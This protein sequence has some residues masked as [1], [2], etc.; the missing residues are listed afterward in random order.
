MK[1]TVTIV[2]HSG[3]FHSD[4]I[5]GVATVSLKL[6]KEGIP[7]KIVR[8]RDPS[9]REKADYV[10]DTGSVYDPDIN[11]FDHHQTGGAGVRDNGVPYATFGLV[12]KKFGEFLCKNKEIVDAVEKKLILPIDALDNGVD[13]FTQVNPAITVYGLRDITLVFRTTWKEDEGELYTRFLFLVDIA[14]KIIQREIIF[15]EDQREANIIIKKTYDTLSDKRVLVLDRG[16]DW[17]DIVTTMPEVMFVVYPKLSDSTWG[18]QNTR[19]NL[20]SYDARVYFPQSWGGKNDTELEKVT[21]V[22]GSI[23]CHKNLWMAVAKTKEAAIK[24]ADIALQDAGN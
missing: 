22:S 24:L 4:D 18:V 20:S 2:T 17:K 1:D 8:T 12:W 19:D 23:F 14:K 21:G 11:R 10:L 13:I 16:Y 9:I 6:E 15:I 3:N 7:F 5:F